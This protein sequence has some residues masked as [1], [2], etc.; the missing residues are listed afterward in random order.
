MPKHADAEALNQTAASSGNT[1]RATTLFRL[2]KHSR[3]LI[4]VILRP[5]A[6]DASRGSHVRAASTTSGAAHGYR[7]S[8]AARKRSALLMT[9]T[10]DRLIAKLAIAGDSSKLKTGNSTPAAIGTPSAL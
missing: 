9:D 4:V 6:T 1:T 3:S 2:R 10:D 7:Y 5:L 8:F